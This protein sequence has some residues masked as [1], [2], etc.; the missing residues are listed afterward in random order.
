M[1]PAGE[2]VEIVVNDLQTV[3]GFVKVAKQGKRS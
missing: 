1:Q 3:Y 2:N